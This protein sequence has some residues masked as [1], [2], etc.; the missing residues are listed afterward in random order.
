MARVPDTA[1]RNVIAVAVLVAV[2]ALVGFGTGRQPAGCPNV[3]GWSKGLEVTI[4]DRGRV[5]A[6]LACAITDGAE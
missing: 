2:G 1:T 6:D 3:S 5:A 4:H